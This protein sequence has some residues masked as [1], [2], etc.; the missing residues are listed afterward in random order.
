MLVSLDVRDYQINYRFVPI[1]RDR[2]NNDIGV[3]NSGAYV[4][5][6]GRT[7]LALQSPARDNRFIV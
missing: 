7:K 4:E 6:C 1:A 3:A 5:G 2:N